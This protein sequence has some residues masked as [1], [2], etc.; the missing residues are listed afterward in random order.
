MASKKTLFL[1]AIFIA[2]LAYVYFFEIQGEK[3]KQ[4]QQQKQELILNID[5]NKVTG[6]HFLP[7]GIILEKENDRWKVISPVQ[8][9]A[10]QSVVESIVAAFSRLKKGRFV[11]DN[12]DDLKKFGLI[13]FLHALVIE[14]QGAAVDS[15]FIGDTNLDNTNVF[16]RR[17]GANSVYLVPTTLKNNVAKSL[18]DLRDKSI[19][20][21]E[22]NLVHKILIETNGQT[23]SCY[24]NKDTGWQ[25]EFP[26][27]T[28]CD[29]AVVEEII[30]KLHTTKVA[31]FEAE[32]TL[33]LQK[34]GL[35]H[36]W[37]MVS[38]F[39]SSTMAQK[40]LYLGKKEESE[41]Y[42]KDDSRPAI[43]LI[44]S[45]LVAKL[46][47]SLYDLSDK[48][49]VSFEQ[50]S[51]VE[52]SLHYPEQVVH[53]KRDS[54]QNWFM[55][56][57]DSGL[58]KSWEVASLLYSIRDLTVAQFLDEPYRSD[59]YY[60]FDKPDIK[61]NLKTNTRD[62]AEL[63]FGKPSQDKVYLKNRLN[64]KIYLVNKK[65]KN[66]FM[67]NHEKFLDK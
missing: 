56:Q 24:K 39:D 14:Q 27:Q 41:Y 38:L 6:L 52:I 48:S 7:E 47:V 54:A 61:L 11:S 10:D 21:F 36:P 31:G 45:S 33:Q 8:T 3:R 15:L 16:Y 63:V 26:I 29:E 28:R 46:A 55:I 23:F 1:L 51:V 25:L 53:F 37:L 59:T 42:A 50:D 44:D 20:K 22:K 62:L 65:A 43:F 35:D 9:D 19:L 49:I 32:A 4:A 57:P 40:T 66:D 30:D 12:S 64:N 60:G 2:L 17:S 5:K 13:P 34:F 58:V 18:F 67:I